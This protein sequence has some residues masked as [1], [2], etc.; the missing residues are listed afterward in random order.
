M[1]MLMHIEQEYAKSG[2]RESEAPIGWVLDGRAFG[3][4]NKDG[5]VSA[6]LPMFFRQAKY[7]SFTR[8]LYRWGF[9]Q[10]TIDGDAETV[11][12]S[13]KYFG[14][15]NFQRQR[16]ALLSNMRS[17]TAAGTRR[18]EAAQ[19]IVDRGSKKTIEPAEDATRTAPVSSIVESTGL[20]AASSNHTCLP[21]GLQN[22]FAISYTEAFQIPALH[23]AIQALSQSSR[24]PL[25]SE[26]AISPDISFQANQALAAGILGSLSPQVN[27]PQPWMIQHALSIAQA[28]VAQHM[29]QRQ[30]FHLPQDTAT[31]QYLLNLSRI[32]ANVTSA[33]QQMV[34]VSQAPLTSISPAPSNS[35]L[36][37]LPAESSPQQMTE[38]DRLRAL[39]EVFLR[40][41]S[42]RAN[43]TPAQPPLD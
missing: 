37:Q 5:L 34:P 42:S 14:N 28:L 27:Q 43:G 35:L 3:I 2:K 25:P 29:A 9:R 21:V 13:I 40:Q 39:V 7:S 10:V 33:G 30:L 19:S 18:E 22:P 17:V 6:W 8:K 36:S 26:I 32:T 1:L 24:L 23:A 11:S 41:Q 38:T 12:T 31:N 15:E 4:Y 20:D 16:K